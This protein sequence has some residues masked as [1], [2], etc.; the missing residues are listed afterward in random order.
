[1]LGRGE[2]IIGVIVESS[3]PVKVTNT[4]NGYIDY[5]YEIADLMCLNIN[6]GELFPAGT[7]DIDSLY[8]STSCQFEITKEEV[9]SK[10][11]SVRESIGT[12]EVVGYSFTSFIRNLGLI[13]RK[14]MSFPLFNSSN[15]F[16]RLTGADTV[17]ISVEN[18]GYTTLCYKDYSLFNEVSLDGVITRVYNPFI[19]RIALRDTDYFKKLSSGVWVSNEDCYI[20]DDI[21]E[22][23][24]DE[25]IK[26][27][28]IVRNAIK[29]LVLSKTVEIIKVKYI[30]LTLLN[31]IYV[32]KEASLSCICHIIA[33]FNSVA[34]QRF[35]NLDISDSELMETIYD[36]MKDKNYE[37]MW[38]YC[39]REENQD[40]MA[41][42]LS[43]VEII[44]Y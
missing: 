5:F 7:L 26:R 6:T 12:K 35:D 34:M 43:N 38:E 21:R 14:C 24:I 37:Y 2:V 36:C 17:G 18:Y 39:N 28:V 33:I 31:R 41:D 42:I 10:F 1:M 19:F 29:S 23:V 22:L 30:E 3:E 11:L 4:D 25:G 20:D 32:S 27:I 44:V 16:I 8:K 13:I 15:K 9:T 40:E